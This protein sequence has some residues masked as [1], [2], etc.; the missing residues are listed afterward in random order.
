MNRESGLPSF[1]GSLHENRDAKESLQGPEREK[2]VTSEIQVWIGRHAEKYKTNAQAE[3]FSRRGEV[4]PVEDI[5]DQMIELTPQGVANAQGKSLPE[6]TENAVAYGGPRIRSRETAGLMMAGA[7]LD[8]SD[9][10]GA[11]EIIE[12]INKQSGVKVG[13]RVGMDRRLDFVLADNPYGVKVEEEYVAGNLMRF[14]ADH[15]KEEAEK[16]GDTES[17]TYDRAAAG[18]AELVLRYVKAAP[19]WDAI[20]EDRKKTGEDTG[21]I[22]RRF[23]GTHQ[24]VGESFL[25]KVIDETRGREERERF[26]DAVKNTGFGFAEGFQIT[27]ENHGKTGEPLLHLSFAKADA[28]GKEVYH[29]EENLDRELLEKIAADSDLAVAA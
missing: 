22:L 29:F 3:A 18:I 1:E 25:A 28:E 14:L 27:M 19:R 4:V 9:D 12:E 11:Q 10:A 7:H 5:T 2:K 21:D 15:S 23:L 24:G 20:V 13:T 17:M 26:F 6:N 8:R 16:A